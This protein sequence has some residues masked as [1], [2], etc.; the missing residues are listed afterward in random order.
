MIFGGAYNCGWFNF[1][2]MSVG[3]VKEQQA[4]GTLQTC[5]CH[6]I[7]KV[8]QSPK[9]Y[10]RI[11]TSQSPR[12]TQF[13]REEEWYYTGTGTVPV[14]LLYLLYQVPLYNFFS[15]FFFRFFSQKVNTIHLVLFQ[16]VST[17]LYYNNQKNSLH[18]FFITQ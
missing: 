4:P 12:R 9:Q 2:T 1:T 10:L 18:F 15:F 11:I 5:N 14:V 3:F 8:Q 17:F 7:R 13:T 6:I 16:I